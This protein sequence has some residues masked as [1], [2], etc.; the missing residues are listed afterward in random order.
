MV[1]KVHDTHD[2]IILQN[3][4]SDV[5]AQVLKLFP[6]KPIAYHLNGISQRDS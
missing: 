5:I 2:Q 6:H 1:S 3:R 4:S